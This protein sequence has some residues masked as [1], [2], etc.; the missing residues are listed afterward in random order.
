MFLLLLLLLVLLSSKGG[1]GSH[2]TDFPCDVAA[3]QA[4]LVREGSGAVLDWK[5]L[6][7]SVGHIN[8]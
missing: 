6:P 4:L 1:D 2:Q 5:R 7:A 3:L 8:E